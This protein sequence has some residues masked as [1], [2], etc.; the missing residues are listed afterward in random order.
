M[1]GLPKIDFDDPRRLLPLPQS[2]EV[3]KIIVMHSLKKEG[4]V[5]PKKV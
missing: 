5:P 3:V 1:Y 4:L 2:M